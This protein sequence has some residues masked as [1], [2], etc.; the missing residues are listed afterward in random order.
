MG[1]PKASKTFFVVLL[2]QITPSVGE[3]PTLFVLRNLQG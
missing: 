1:A 3:Y 2:F